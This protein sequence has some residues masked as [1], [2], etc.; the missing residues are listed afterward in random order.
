MTRIA[1]PLIALAIPALLAAQDTGPAISQADVDE[2]NAFSNPNSIEC[3][4]DSIAEWELAVRKKFGLARWGT[5]DGKIF[6]FSSQTV[7]VPI[8]DPDFAAGLANAFSMA[9]SE[10]RRE[11]ARVR[12]GH[13]SIEE[14][15]QFYQD[16]STNRRQI[17]VE[18]PAEESSVAQKASP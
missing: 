16:D 4:E 14:L 12:F 11:I 17:D 8:S 2:Q 13:N 15:R 7:A 10:A 5:T 9:V 18:I 6:H 3:S 1:L